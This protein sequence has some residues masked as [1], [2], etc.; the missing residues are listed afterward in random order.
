MSEYNKVTLVQKKPL[1]VKEVVDMAKRL[2]KGSNPLETGISRIDKTTK[3]ILR[4]IRGQKGKA[5]VVNVSVH[6]PDVSVIVPSK[7]KGKVKDKTEIKAQSKS[8]VKGQQS[9]QS[10]LKSKTPSVQ[11]PA[12]LKSSLPVKAIAKS[13]EP[14]TVTKTKS[15][16]PQIQKPALATKDKVKDKTPTLKESDKKVPGAKQKIPD[17]KADKTPK[18]KKADEMSKERAASKSAEKIGE[19]VA[20]SVNDQAEKNKKRDSLLLDNIGKLSKASDTAGMA[21]GGPVF[22]AMKEGAELFKADKDSMVGRL[23]GKLNDK[24]GIG[25][26]VKNVMGKV[27]EKTGVKKAH[28]WLYGDEKERA[29]KRQGDDAQVNLENFS[30]SGGRFKDDQ[31]KFVSREKAVALQ[32]EKES[33]TSGKYD[34][35]HTEESLSKVKKKI[36]IEQ[37]EK[38]K[39]FFSNPILQK[40]EQ[41]KPADLTPAETGKS[42]RPQFESRKDQKTDQLLSDINETLIDNDSDLKKRDKDRNKAIKKSRGGSGGG[43]LLGSLMNMIPGGKKG[44]LLTKVLGKSKL[45]R[46][47][48]KMGSLAGKAGGLLGIGG[49]AVGGVAKAGGGMLKGG[50]KMAGKVAGKLP[51]IGA[52]VTAGMAVWDFADGM[53]MAA[54]L[55]GKAE[56]GLTA[57]EKTQAGTANAF[58]GLTFGLVSTE[59][60]FKGVQAATDFVKGGVSNVTSAFDNLETLTGKSA[61]NLTIADKAQA[62]YSAGLSALAYGFVDSSTI[63]KGINTVLKGISGGFE[64]A[65]KAIS[66]VGTYIEDK[67]GWLIKKD[68]DPPSNNPTETPEELLKRAKSAKDSWATPQKALQQI[69][70][71]QVS[72]TRSRVP[73]SVDRFDKAVREIKEVRTAT[74]T[75]IERTNNTVQEKLKPVF[76][77]IDRIPVP[78]HQRTGTQA[79]LLQGK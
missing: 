52:L 5:P 3:E 79:L 25:D 77:D 8:Q 54:K 78:L 76:A 42:D 23:M 59:T 66:G 71:R 40:D 69:N 34:Q 50:L 28:N 15:E 29:K 19:A 35:Y 12:S 37:R 30:K 65:G 57:L 1:K 36:K 43:G 24:T 6:A 75:I 38:A 16:S 74:E 10:K 2:R 70:P 20:S 41:S 4:A 49:A 68:P 62:A 17:T 67:L 73:N 13:V 18:N 63:F 61:N 53:D 14:K 47:A 58:S 21:L 9:G 27:E 60:A 56:K 45:G 33:K 26:K 72:K 22:Q 32:K 44:G 7:K 64:K 46:G 55:T 48:L 39:V 31:G 11:K 51:I